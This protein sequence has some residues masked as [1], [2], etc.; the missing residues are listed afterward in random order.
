MDTKG[1]ESG[2]N[3]FT[4]ENAEMNSREKAAAG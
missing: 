2:R 3:V 1:H 4:T